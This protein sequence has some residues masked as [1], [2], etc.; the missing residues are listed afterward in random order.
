MKVKFDDI[1]QVDA[2]D[3]AI[4]FIAK[5]C[6]VD[7]AKADYYRRGIV[8]YDKDITKAL[9]EEEISEVFSLDRYKENI[10]VIYSRV[11]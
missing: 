8:K 1:H 3:D 5:Y 11:Y 2:L 6:N 7:Y 9:T 4:D 10:E